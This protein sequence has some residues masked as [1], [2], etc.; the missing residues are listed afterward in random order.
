MIAAASLLLSLAALQLLCAVVRPVAASARATLAV[1]PAASLAPFP[2]RDQAMAGK[3][4]GSE[5]VTNFHMAYLGEIPVPAGSA[6]GGATYCFEESHFG[7]A[8]VGQ[9]L[10]GAS[11]CCT[12]DATA[13]AVKVTSIQVFLCEHSN[14]GPA[15]VS[16]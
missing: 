4:A 14:D 16:C 1:T 5:D 11:A 2:R 15:P 10:P 8:G 9:C 7:G 3:L 13:S 6:G 12:T